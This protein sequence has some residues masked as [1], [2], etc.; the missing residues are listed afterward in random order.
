MS[1]DLS[2]KRFIN[3]MAFV[4]TLFVALAL[5]VKHLLT[6]L[7][8]GTPTIISVIENIGALIAYIVLMTVAF[9]YV[10]TKRKPIWYI[11]YTIS[12]TAIVILVIMNFVIV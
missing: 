2:V 12:V 9:F 7:E 4:G 11:L 1:S 8:L 5:L 3:M 10:R 6:W